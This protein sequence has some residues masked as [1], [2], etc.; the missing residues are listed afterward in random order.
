MSYSKL[1]VNVRAIQ[2]AGNQAA[3]NIRQLVPTH[4][5][6]VEGTASIRWSGHRQFGVVKL[7]LE[8]VVIA[9]SVG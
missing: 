2:V 1:M 6:L 4:S 8:L 3:S 9:G 7:R 5:R